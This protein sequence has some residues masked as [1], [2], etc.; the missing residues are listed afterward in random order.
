[1]WG[2]TALSTTY[3]APTQPD[4]FDPGIAAGNGRDRFGER[5][6]ASAGRRNLQCRDIHSHGWDSEGTEH[7]ADICRGGERCVPANR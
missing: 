5:G 4:R 6:D 7:F 1:M 2:S 3:Q